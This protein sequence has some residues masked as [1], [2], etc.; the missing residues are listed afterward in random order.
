MKKKKIVIIVIIVVLLLIGGYFVYFSL[1]DN[2]D[3]NFEDEDK[4]ISF[5]L[6]DRKI[7]IPVSGNG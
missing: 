3:F 2:L 7:K 1:N 5:Y 4:Y 6:V